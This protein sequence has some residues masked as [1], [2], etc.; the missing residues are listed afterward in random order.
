MGKLKS[1]LV[2]QGM[3]EGAVRLSIEN[4]RSKGYR[5]TLVPAE[6]RIVK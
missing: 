5:L 1:E 6:I 2:K 3:D 4:Q